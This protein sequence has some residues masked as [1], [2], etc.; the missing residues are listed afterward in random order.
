MSRKLESVEEALLALGDPGDSRWGEAL[1][2]LLEQP[3][4][5]TLLLEAFRETLEPRKSS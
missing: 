2:Y 1:G 5:A 4:T 3:R